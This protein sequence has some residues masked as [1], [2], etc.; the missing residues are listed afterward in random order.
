MNSAP[1]MLFQLSS[2][3]AFQRHII[4]GYGFV[5]I[6]TTPGNYE[7]EGENNRRRKARATARHLNACT[8]LT[9]PNLRL[10]SLVAVKLWVPRGGIRS[11]LRDF[12]IGGAYRLHDLRSIEMPAD[13]GGASFLSKFG[14][15]TEKS[16]TLKVR[17]SV[18]AHYQ[19]PEME[20]DGS[21]DG[22]MGR[23]QTLN[24][25]SSVEDILARVR[26]NRKMGVKVSAKSG[27]PKAPMSPLR[28]RSQLMDSQS[29]SSKGQTFFG[30]KEEPSLS[31]E[32]NEDTFGF[33]GGGS[34]MLGSSNELLARVKARKAEREKRATTGNE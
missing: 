3:H 13:M 7:I 25:R 5:K 34:K 30:D 28:R 6:P 17:M 15:R 22:D 32:S 23:T 14:F 29:S 27:T 21:M 12:F 9:Q 4:E 16:G 10:T 8:H 26:N 20:G 11:E 31:A 33:G 2:K 19:P 1:S 24:G 18:A